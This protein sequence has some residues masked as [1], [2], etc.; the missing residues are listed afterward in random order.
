MDINHDHFFLKSN[1]KQKVAQVSYNVSYLHGLVYIPRFVHSLNY[2]PPSLKR[3]SLKPSFLELLI[4][5][6]VSR[7]ED[8]TLT[9]KYFYLFTK[10]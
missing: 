4:D 8:K 3:T 7:E 9:E 1:L 6:I 2:I 5:F 10:E